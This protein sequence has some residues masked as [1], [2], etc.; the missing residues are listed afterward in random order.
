MIIIAE[1]VV[2]NKLK[3]NNKK[4]NP[5][6]VSIFVCL[7]GWLNSVRILSYSDEKVKTRL[8]KI[9]TKIEKCLFKSFFKHVKC[10][11]IKLHKRNG[12]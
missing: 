7:L 10:D 12:C 3:K 2:S 8:T 4:F 6:D 5:C 9:F 1:I 11:I